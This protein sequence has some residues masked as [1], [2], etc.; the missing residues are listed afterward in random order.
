MRLRRL[1]LPAALVLALAS[2]PAIAA[3]QR[4]VY[5]AEGADAGLFDQYDNDGYSLSVST[6][7]A[8]SLELKVRVDDAP[9]VSTAPFPTRA[10]R[11]PSLTAAD[12]RDAFA[13]AATRGSA[14][15][16]D[17]VSRLLLALAARVSYDPDR[18]RPQDPASVFASRRASCVGFA[19]LAVDL[20]RR[21]GIAARTVQGILSSSGGE[22]YEAR[23]GGSFH[24][25]I[26]V[27][28]ADR[29]YVFS[30]PSASINGVDARYIPFRG[31]SLLRP[32]DLILVR[33]TQSGGLSYPPISLGGATLRARASGP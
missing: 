27:Y 29:G 6:T 12:D 24:R 18:R 25:W 20:L 15:Q 11:D 30:D 17:A 13:S 33:V 16:S 1:G 28:Y 23:I 4:A 31:R 26:E 32:K 7:S 8:G 14:R 3:E 9:L 19:E 22:A 21:T 2:G 5:L 10:A